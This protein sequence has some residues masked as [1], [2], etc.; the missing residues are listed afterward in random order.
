MEV[1]KTSTTQIW[2]W[3]I[4]TATSTA[5][6]A[7]KAGGIKGLTLGRSDTFH[8][9][10]SIIEIDPEFNARDFTTPEN[11][12]HVN[13]LA[14]LI[15]AHGVKEPLRVYM[16]GD[17]PVCT[18]GESRLR[19][20]AQLRDRGVIIASVPVQTEDRYSNDVDRLYTQTTSNSGKPFTPMEMSNH[21]RRLLNLGQTPDQIAD[22]TAMDVRRVK[23]LL[24]LQTLPGAVQAM[25]TSGTIKAT[26][27]METFVATGRDETKTIDTLKGAVEN[28]VAAGAKKVSKKFVGGEG[29][30][31]KA[32]PAKQMK[33]DRTELAAI[34]ASADFADDADEDGKEIT[35]ITVTAEQA[36]RIKAIFAVA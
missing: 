26:L 23:Q 8:L 6:T 4:M 17:V 35:V 33:T 25:I 11:I 29:G 21:F 12:E 5:Q 14:A 3:K 20:I 13:T 10:P 15:E 1:A 32:S 19:A 27:A 36:A 18:N 7:K 34:F 2:D 9:D 28:A 30:E 22:K 31:R 16:R 24:D